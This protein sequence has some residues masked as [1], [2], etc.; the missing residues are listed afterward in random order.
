[1]ARFQI[2][3]I[4]YKPEWK[5]ELQ[6]MMH[7]TI[8]SIQRTKGTGEQYAIL[9]NFLHALTYEW[10]RMRQELDIGKIDLRQENFKKNKVRK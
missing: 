7:K 10:N 4:T 1:M 8:T 6:Y 5:L 9:T 2:H 3:H